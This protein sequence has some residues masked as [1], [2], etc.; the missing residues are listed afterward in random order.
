M[1]SDIYTLE[2]LES[3]FRAIPAEAEKV[4]GYNGLDDKSTRRLRLLSEEMICMLPQLLIYGKGQFWIENEGRNYELHL[5]V[6]PD[7]TDS[8]D[9]EAVIGVS[10]N[11]KNA[12]AKGIISKICCMV[13]TML[14]ENAKIA[15]ENPY[16]FSMAYSPAYPGGMTWSLLSYRNALSEPESNERSEEWDE[17]EK[18]IIS[19]LADE[20]KVWLE[21]DSTQVVIERYFNV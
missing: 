5:H 8:F 7:D 14:D 17:L 3:D 9:R 2:S 16:G 13:E 6:K 1:K 10:T 21:N 11:K 19:K 4:A 20:V 15:K 12:A 18:S